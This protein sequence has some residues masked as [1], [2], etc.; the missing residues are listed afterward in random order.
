MALMLIL[1][2]SIVIAILR[3][4]RASREALQSQV[5]QGMPVAVSS[6]TVF[7]LWA[8]VLG[9]EHETRNQT[10]LQAFMGGASVGVVDL[11][12]S[13]AVQGAAVQATLRRIGRPIGP[14]DT[15]I[16]GQVLA[17]G[18]RLATRNVQE[19]SRVAGLAL[20]PWPTA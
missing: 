15:L 11:T 3:G 9:S 4:E 6:V 16:A 12:A 10:R 18:A 1:D 19:F 2:T 17:R 7:E 5:Q 8:G 13:D 20:L 14:M